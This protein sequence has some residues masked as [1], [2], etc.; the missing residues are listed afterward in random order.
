MP[1]AR[2]PETVLKGAEF[3]QKPQ[4][5]L[6]REQDGSKSQR[7]ILIYRQRTGA[8]EIKNLLTGGY[9]LEAAVLGFRSEASDFQEPALMQKSR[10][11]S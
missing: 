6:P 10:L 4:H 8:K 1:P 2:L 9:S 5:P 7:W 11:G 3:A